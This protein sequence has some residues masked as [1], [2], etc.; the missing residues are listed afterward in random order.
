MKNRS[1]VW[2]VEYSIVQNAL[3]E[4]MSAYVMTMKLTSLRKISTSGNVIDAY[5]WL[6]RDKAAI[7]WLV[8]ADM[9]FA[10][11]VEVQGMESILTI[12]VLKRKEFLL[13]L[14]LLQMKV[15]IKALKQLMMTVLDPIFPKIF[16]WFIFL[17]Y[18][19]NQQSFHLLILLTK[20][21]P[22]K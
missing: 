22:H 6:R 10:I 18:F 2:P 14:L 13:L 16:E 11:F 20:T 7:T 15:S 21:I 4:N 9:A 1:F 17:S 5:S 19:I 8:V 3:I 12:A